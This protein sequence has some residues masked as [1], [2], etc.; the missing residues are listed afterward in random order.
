MQ[1]ILISLTFSLFEHLLC[2]YNF[3]CLIILHM[4]FNRKKILPKKFFK[5]Q[6]KSK[7]KFLYSLGI[8]YE[9]FTF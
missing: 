9:M 1:I 2:T 4:P 6:I 3:T 7:K 5:A 8:V